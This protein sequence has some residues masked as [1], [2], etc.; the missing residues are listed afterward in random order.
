MTTLRASRPGRLPATRAFIAG[1]LCLALA[2]MPAVAQDGGPALNP[3]RPDR[4]VVQKGD[5]LWG[6]SS[7]YLRDPWLWPEIWYVNPQVAN[8]HLIFPGDVLSLV[9]V[10]G[11]PQLRLERA[12]DAAGGADRLSPRIREEG[13]DGAITTIPTA[14]IEAFLSRG[15]VLQRREVNKLPYIV[16]VREGLVAAGPG[17]EAYVRGQVGGEDS[18]YSVIHVGS[19]IVDPDD[20]DL[21]GYEGIYVGEGTIRRG[22]DPAT[23]ALTDSAREARNGDRLVPPARDLPLQFIPR[24]PEQPVDGRIIRVVDGMTT[25]GAYQVV[26]LNR[27]TKHGLEPGHVLTVTQ[28]GN[29]VT[30]NVQPGVFG[31]NVRLPDEEAGT[32]MVF[33]SYD[34]LSYALVMRSSVPMRALD[35]IVNPS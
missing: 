2:G 34:R 14:A 8:P 9:Y 6:I 32:V 28:G 21:L 25:F 13:L 4:Y 11:K 17:Q 26:V 22:G 16:T 33:R 1:L 35:R 31:R 24:A 3:D 12:A 7:L 19:R 20:G 15:T 10:D 30:D 23:L 5:T 27:G 18:I 29:R